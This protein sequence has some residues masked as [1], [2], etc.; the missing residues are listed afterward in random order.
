MA[1]AVIGDP[2]NTVDGANRATDTS[3]DDTTNSAAHGT[4]NAVTLVRP[5][6]GPA[7]N[8]LSVARLRQ[9]SQGKK[10]GG[11]REEQANG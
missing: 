8:A 4:S 1:A 6:L 11:G 7:H 10:D 2:Q 9:A 3:A 5:F